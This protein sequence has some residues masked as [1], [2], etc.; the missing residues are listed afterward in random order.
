MQGLC[1]IAAPVEVGLGSRAL[2]SGGAAGETIQ[3]EDRW[4]DRD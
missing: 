2:Q 1:I 4:D 3:T